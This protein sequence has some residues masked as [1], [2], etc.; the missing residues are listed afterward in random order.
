MEVLHFN[1]TQL[2]VFD[3]ISGLEFGKESIDENDEAVFTKQ[4]YIGNFMPL[5]DALVEMYEDGI[6]K[7]YTRI[8]LTFADGTKSETVTVPLKGLEKIDWSND[9]NLRCIL[10]PDVGKVSEHIAN[11]IRLQ[12]A[13]AQVEKMTIINSLGTHFVEQIPVFCTGNRLIWPEGIVDKPSVKWS[14]LPNMK[15]AIN[16]DCPEE[17]AVSG[18]MR[19]GN[20]S[21]EAGTIIF[22]QNLLYVMREA[23]VAAG[24]TPRAIV[25][26]HRKTGVKKTT[27]S[28][29]QTQ[30]YNRDEPLEPLTRLNATI[31][32]A[33]NLLY[34][35]RGCIV[36]FD[37]LFPAQDHEIHRQQEK[38]LLEL[39]RVIGDGIEPARMR[40]WK[41][42]KEPPRCG[43][44]F[45]GEYYIGSGS[46]A[47]RL[48][49]VNITT[50]IDNDKLTA[51]Q[52]EPLMLST[53]YN[54]FITWYITHF[55]DIVNL[56][57]EWIEVYRSTKTDIHARLQET[58]FCLEAAFKLFLTYCGDKGFVS[59]EAT[60]ER[61]NSFYQQLR[62]IV[63]DQNDRVSKATNVMETVRNKIDYLALI[64]SLYHDKLFNLS[65]SVKNF[66]RDEHDGVIHDDC[67][68]LRRE[69]LMAK[70]KN[71]NPPSDFENVLKCLKEQQALKPGKGGS[72]SRKLHGGGRG[73][74]FYAI[75]LGKLR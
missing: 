43:I 62:A 58:Q 70:L 1:K 73:L 37:D 11:V 33:V 6:S 28:S 49:P 21:P 24:T 60:V 34:E 10:N 2:Y 20:L 45:T 65:N 32:A 39:T 64:R 69:K 17:E 3:V 55:D 54:Y 31:A 12:C 14:P 4:K 47:A 29:F 15:L 38:T 57:K 66:N 7:Q 5:V 50:P 53:F 51:C 52:N 46:D 44:L 27:Y 35:K 26:L 36:V 74:N 68:F 63:R 9:I 42:A 56:L 48:L 41:V 16:P 13:K 59:H 23:F 19:I 67:L 72:S 30:L 25:Y 61:Y 71:S 75:R 8:T 40:G 22:S 18:M